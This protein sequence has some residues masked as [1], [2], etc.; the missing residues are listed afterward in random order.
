MP[1]CFLEDQNPKIRPSVHIDVVGSWKDNFL[2]KKSKNRSIFNRFLPINGKRFPERMLK[3]K[4]EGGNLRPGRG[5]ISAKRASEIL[6]RAIES[7]LGRGNFRERFLKNLMHK[8]QEIEKT[9]RSLSNGR[10]EHKGLFSSDEITEE[11]DRA[12][13]EVASQVYYSLLAKKTKELE[14]IEILVRRVQK[15][16]EFG[17]CDECGERI[18]EERLLIVPEATRCVR[19]QKE[20]ERFESR[21]GLEKTS[22]RLSRMKKEFQRENSS[23]SDEEEGFI[24]NPDTEKFSI[25]DLEETELVNYPVEENEK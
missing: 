1:T 25:F 24:F 20:I 22:N 14:R 4:V 5:E 2:L 10:K 7:P 8:K 3:E 18:P 9:I 16:N 23:Y 19:C 6:T 15:E 11:M 12:E 13:I 17:L 21:K